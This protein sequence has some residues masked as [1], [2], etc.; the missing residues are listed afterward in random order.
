MILKLF[1]NT[2]KICLILQINTAEHKIAA[3]SMCN[4]FTLPVPVAERMDNFIP[5]IKINVSIS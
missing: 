3:T 4:T 2:Q 5:R 1:L